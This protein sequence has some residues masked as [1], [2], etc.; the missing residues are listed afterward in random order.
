MTKS[1]YQTNNKVQNS[2]FQTLINLDERK[3]SIYFAPLPGFI[4]ITYLSPALGGL[5]NQ[6]VM[7]DTRY[8]SPR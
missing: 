1:K 3:R 5:T 8:N 7:A 6:M 4:Q 2:K